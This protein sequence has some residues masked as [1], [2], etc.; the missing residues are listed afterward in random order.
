MNSINVK[1]PGNPINLIPL[2][3]TIYLQLLSDIINSRYL[4]FT[5]TESPSLCG[6]IRLCQ[7]TLYSIYN[8]LRLKQLFL[9]CDFFSNYTLIYYYFFHFFQK[10][11]TCELDVYNRACLAAFILF[12]F[13][14]DVYSLQELRVFLNCLLS[15]KLIYFFQRNRMFEI[16]FKSGT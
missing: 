7:L 3:E 11:I 9:K 13:F 5:L 15:R 2:S 6:S 8:V 10:Y 16:N 14:I 12:L 1:M 4:L